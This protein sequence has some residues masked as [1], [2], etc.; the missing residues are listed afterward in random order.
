M[1]TS[2]AVLVVGWVVLGHALPPPKP[3]VDYS[4]LAHRIYEAR[5]TALRQKF[6]AKGGWQVPRLPAV[7]KIAAPDR[8]SQP[9]RDFQIFGLQHLAGC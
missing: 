6:A 7:E 2:V 1:R 4:A 8:H 9:L 3:F 5:K